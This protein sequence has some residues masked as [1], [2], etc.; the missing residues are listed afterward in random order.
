MTQIIA[1]SAEEKQDNFRRCGTF[2]DM[3]QF[4]WWR[5]DLF[6]STKQ[7]NFIDITLV[8]SVNEAKFNPTGKWGNEIK[9][10]RKK[11][12]EKFKVFRGKCA[13]HLKKFEGDTVNSRKNL[14]KYQLKSF[15]SIGPIDM[16]IE[17]T[18][19]LCWWTK[20]CCPQR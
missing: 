2:T 19:Y 7:N 8:F 1:L 20:H 16:L 17:K 10:N 11:N 15:K 3:V 5:K 6:L 13:V 14:S 12:C 18:N 4:H 9:E